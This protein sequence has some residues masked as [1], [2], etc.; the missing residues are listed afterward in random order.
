MRAMI[1][2]IQKLQMNIR[3]IPT[4]TMIPPSEI[5]PYLR[6]AMPAAPFTS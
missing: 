6:S 5:P 2:P 4:M 1:K 3:T